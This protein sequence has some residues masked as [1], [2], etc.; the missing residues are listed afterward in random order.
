MADT[1]PLATIIAKYAD[2]MLDA[3]AASIVRAGY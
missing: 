1:T 2:Q 3:I